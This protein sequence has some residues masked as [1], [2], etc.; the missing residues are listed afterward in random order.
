[1]QK[2]TLFHLFILQIK[3]PI[4]RLATPIFNHAHSKNFQAPFN[5]PEMVIN[6]HAKNL[7]IPSVYSRYTVNFKL[8]RP[9]CLLLPMPNQKIFDQLFFVNLYQNVKKEAVSSICSG[10][11]VDL[12]ILQPN[13]LR[14]FWSTSQEQDFSQI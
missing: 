1:M 13:W 2:I 3:S 5:L 9:D 6:L 11:R 14:A 7:L 12:K 10:E 4:I 8:Q